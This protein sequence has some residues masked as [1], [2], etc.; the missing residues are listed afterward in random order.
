MGNRVAYFEIPSADPQKNML[1]Y[2]QAFG[3]TFQ[4]FHNQEYWFAITGNEEE[5]GINGAVMKEVSPKQP[6]INTILVNNIDQS[7]QAIKKAGGTIIK[8]KKAI[9]FIGW[10]AFFSDP[11]ENIFGIMQ[12]DRD[13]Y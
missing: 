7:L 8:P 5:Q 3:W 11:D 10:L 12:E 4:Q 6:L 2:E 1:F 9:R 13:A